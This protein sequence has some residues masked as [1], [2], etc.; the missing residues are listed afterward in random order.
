M[1][2]TAL[3]LVAVHD[4]VPESRHT[5]P[6]GPPVGVAAEEPLSLYLWSDP[7]GNF[8]GQVLL[9]LAPTAEAAREL[10]VTEAADVDTTAI[11]HYRAFREGR[12]ERPLGAYRNLWA[13]LELAPRRI[14][15]PVGMRLRPLT[16]L[17]MARS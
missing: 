5:A 17:G 8:T 16:T 15:S 2:A 9:A 11:H 4:G 14:A 7:G 12:R 6:P 13:Q 3:E 1:T 10:I